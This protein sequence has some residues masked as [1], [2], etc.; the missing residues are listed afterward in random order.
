MTLIFDIE[1]NGLLDET[2]TI[3]CLC[4]KDFDQGREWSLHGKDIEYGVHLLHE[5]EVIVGHNVIKFDIPAI[6][7]VYPWFRPQGIVRD[8]LVYSRL[9]YPDLR[10]IDFARRRKKSDLPGKLIGSHGLKAWGYRLGNYKG[11]YEGPWDSWSKDMQDYCE[12][13]VRVTFDLYAKFLSKNPS[14]QAVDLEHKVA[15]IIGRQERYGF[16][17]DSAAA[18]SLYAVLL[19]RRIDIGNALRDAFPPW[20]I[21]EE[22]IPKRNNKTKGYIA[23]VPIEKVSVCEFNPNS[24]DHIAFKLQQ[25]YGWKPTKFTN[26]DGK[27]A[28]DETILAKL[29]YPEAKLLSEYLMLTKRIGQLAEG[30][31]SWLSSE[32]AGAIFGSVN[33]NGAVTGRMTHASPNIA[34]VPSVRAPWG[35]ECRALFKAREGKVLVGCDADALELRCLA[36][37]MALYDGGKY[38]KTVLE[39]KKEDGTDMHSVTCRGIGFEPT[40]KYKI[41]GQE[42]TGRDGAKKWFYAFI[43]GA[44]DGKLGSIFGK[45]YKFGKASRQKFLR[46]LPALGKLVGAVKAKVAKRG[47]LIGLDGRHLRIR[48]EHAALNT[49]LQS[50]GAVF[51]KQ[52]LVLLDDKLTADGLVPGVDYE[53]V[54]NV[55]DEWQIEVTD[56][57]QDQ[58]G[59]TAVWAIEEA[60]R[61]FKFRCPLT[62]NYA[63]GQT[64]ADT[65]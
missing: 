46:A 62:G 56:G 24:R 20:E 14:P 28:I 40:Q 25:K 4:I 63:A 11:D 60:G 16:A 22:F 34:Q 8:T 41:Y 17:F 9:L 10:E 55:H 15:T 48:S 30:K 44:G 6:Q 64:W 52:A 33:T 54:A 29:P 35:K 3:H 43:Y 26:E 13:D 39:G 49:L 53:F 45:S 38:V 7:K 32:K 61:H 59:R 12:Q 18:R 57:L 50:A 36:G 65:H 23:G 47:Y 27:P 37:Y 2:N 21:V 31:A 5:A 42:V 19:A 1:T 58:V 51:M